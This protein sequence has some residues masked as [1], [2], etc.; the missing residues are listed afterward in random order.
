MLDAHLAS[1]TYLAG[2]AFTMAD[3]PAGCSVDR[4]YKLP[5]TREAHSNIERWYASLR[6][7]PGA[8]QVVA[9]T[10]S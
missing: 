1:H 4:W 9:L 7:R 3:I 6:A 5:L 8:A 10:L 2:D